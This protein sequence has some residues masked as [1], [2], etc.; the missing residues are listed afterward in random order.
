MRVA[1]GH[2]LY[3]GFGVHVLGLA[4]SSDWKL[5]GGVASVG[6]GGAGGH[7]LVEAGVV[8]HA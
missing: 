8:D 6:V 7:G 1:L 4:L 5:E 3:H 2:V